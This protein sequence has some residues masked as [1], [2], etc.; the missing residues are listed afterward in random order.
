M[1]RRTGLRASVTSSKVDSRTYLCHSK[2]SSYDIVRTSIRLHNCSD[3]H[4]KRSDIGLSTTDDMS[5]AAEINFVVCT[6]AFVFSQKH[7]KEEIRCKSYRDFL[8]LDD[9]KKSEWVLQ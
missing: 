2:R 7:G 5:K 8:L 3:F 9:L 1:R 6:G 4:G